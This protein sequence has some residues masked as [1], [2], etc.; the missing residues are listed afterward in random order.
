MVRGCR[1]KCF[2]DNRTSQ[3]VLNSEAERT[4]VVLKPLI[5]AVPLQCTNRGRWTSRAPVTTESA[6]SSCRVSS[7]RFQTIHCSVFDGGLV[8]TLPQKH[9]RRLKTDLRSIHL[10]N[11]YIIFL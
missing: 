10:K 5:P 2:T 1:G 4:R 9:H 8:Q 7:S 11:Y 3:T 6:C